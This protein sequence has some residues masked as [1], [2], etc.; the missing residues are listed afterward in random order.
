MQFRLKSEY[1][2]LQQVTK[3]ANAT[4]RQLENATRQTQTEYR[5]M[6]QQITRNTEEL[7]KR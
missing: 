7:L 3:E 6:Q 5:K 2:K 1:E 4:L